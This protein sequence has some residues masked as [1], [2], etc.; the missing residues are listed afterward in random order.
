MARNIITNQHK[1]MKE[2]LEES[3]N[4]ISS[5]KIVRKDQK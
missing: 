1:I 5:Y 4:E 3:V 2:E